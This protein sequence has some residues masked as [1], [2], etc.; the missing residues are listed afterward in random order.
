MPGVQPD[1]RLIELIRQ[2]MDTA[3]WEAAREFARAHPELLE[4]EVDFQFQGLAELAFA[5]DDPELARQITLHQGA[6]R[7]AREIGLDAAFARFE[8][9]PDP[10]LSAQLAR[11]IAAPDWETSRQVLNRFPLLVSDQALAILEA[12]IREAIAAGEKQSAFNLNSHLELLQDARAIGYERAFAKLNA[13]PDEA[14]AAVIMALIAAGDDP[15]SAKAFI[16]ANPILLT[17][18]ADHTFGPLIQAAL[19]LNNIPQANWLI[20]YRDLIRSARRSGLEAAFAPMLTDLDARQEKDRPLEEVGVDQVLALIVTNTLAV[21]TTVKER[22]D[23]WL[24]ALAD[25]GEEAGKL[26]DAQM[27]ALI[28]AV[29]AHLSGE[30]D[31]PDLSGA[32]AEAW[33]QIREG[34]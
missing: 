29:Q 34:W 16:E 23:D 33:D 27:V 20:S 5:N 25:I 30:D 22:H 11:F 4:R 8:R 2:Y 13:Q 17:D 32:Y 19:A 24:T 10:E 26:G 18:D 6:L 14:I 15:Q 21:L 9:D 7:D 12:A 1:P 31:S 28:G 3:D